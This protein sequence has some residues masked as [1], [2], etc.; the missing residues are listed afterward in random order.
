MNSTDSNEVVLPELIRIYNTSDIDFEA[1]SALY[2]SAFP[3]D[4]R[5]SVDVLKKMINQ[6]PEMVFYTIILNDLFAGFLIL[7]QFEKFFYIEHLA[8]N[9]KQRSF[10]LGKKVIESI[11]QIFPGIILLEVEPPLDELS[12]RRVRFYERSGYKTVLKKYMQPPYDKNKKPIPMWVL[13]NDEQ[14][15]DS[16]LKEYLTTIRLKVYE[17]PSGMF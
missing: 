17:L 15:S 9:D 4:E 1:I 12:V 5:R 11:K 6:Q 7:W 14:I 16:D 2:I 13:S 3:E 10:G 8:I